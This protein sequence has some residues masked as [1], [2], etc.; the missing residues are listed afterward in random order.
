MADERKPMLLVLLVLPT[1]ASWAATRAWQQQTPRATL[2]PQLAA[3][4]RHGGRLGAAAPYTC[5]KAFLP[6]PPLRPRASAPQMRLRAELV[7]AATA[8]TDPAAF[9]ALDALAVL[10]KVAWRLAAAAA[11]WFAIWPVFK[12]DPRFRPIANY[13]RKI[14]PRAWKL[15]FVAVF[16]RKG[17]MALRLVGERL[18]PGADFSRF[19][20]GGKLSRRGPRRRTPHGSGGGGGGSNGGGGGGGGDGGD[21]SGGDGGGFGGGAS[22]PLPDESARIESATAEELLAEAAELI[23]ACPF[24]SEAVRDE[25]LR[26]TAPRPLVR[27]GQETPEE[28]GWQELRTVRK[29]AIL[30][31][32]SPQARALLKRALRLQ[33]AAQYKIHARDHPEWSQNQSGPA[34]RAGT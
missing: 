26:I 8:A 1:T 14:N 13:V 25:W 20:R 7:A 27:T 29:E 21:G 9:L 17:M 30:R 23:A 28:A 33:K 16:Y 15:L 22:A 4:Q 31:Q 10:L 5:R 24:R 3:A 2:L 11:I 18:F 6:V 19:S 34:T 32:A 12:D